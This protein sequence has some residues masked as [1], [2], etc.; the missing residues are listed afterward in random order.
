MVADL[1]LVCDFVNSVELE[2]G[3]DE[4]A[5]G[6]GLVRW[7]SSHGL[8]GEHARATDADAADA[9][10]LREALRDLMR[11]NSG[12]PADRAAAAALLDA[13]GRRAALAV[14]FDTGSIRL[15]PRE[16]GVRGALGVV[17]G[18]AGEA[19]ADGSWR[20]AKACRSETCRWAFVDRSRN[21]SRQWC[22]MSVCGNRAKA[23]AFRERRG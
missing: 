23:R 4:L 7:L 14:R 15:V 11:A 21:Q 16:R 17:L 10:A 20:R 3:G 12:D 22:S 6:R 19:M 1:Q 2:G 8:A 9:R 13:S 5:D 18:A